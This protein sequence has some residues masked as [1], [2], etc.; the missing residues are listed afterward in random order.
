[1]FNTNQK[2]KMENQN[3]K[4]AAHGA[5]IQVTSGGAVYVTIN[6]TTVYFE[7]GSVG[8]SLNFWTEDMEPDTAIDLVECME[9]FDNSEVK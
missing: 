9:H 7:N 6:G 5:E 8:L 1:M 4:L 2:N 3:V